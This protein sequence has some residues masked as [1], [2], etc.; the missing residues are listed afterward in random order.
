MSLIDL[1]RKR[2][3]ATAIPANTAIAI[4]ANTET[5][6]DDEK[7]WMWE[8]QF[9]DRELLIVTTTPESTYREMYA[10]YPNAILIYPVNSN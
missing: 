8:I 5:D 4:S 10:D 7:H 9:A 6:K 1:I 2:P 3:S